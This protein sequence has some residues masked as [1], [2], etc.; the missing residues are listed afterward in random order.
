MTEIQQSS[1]PSFP[2]D[3]QQE[4]EEIITIVTLLNQINNTV[5]FV[6]KT[7]QIQIKSNNPYNQSMIQ[8]STDCKNDITSQQSPENKSLLSDLIIN[9]LSGYS[10]YFNK[11]QITLSEKFSNEIIPQIIDK[12]SSNIKLVEEINQDCLALNGVRAKYKLL[13]GKEAKILKEIEE[14]YNDKKTIENDGKKSYNLTLKEKN[15][16]LLLNKLNEYDQ[17]R[18]QR[19]QIYQESKTLEKKINNELN[20]LLSTS[21]KTIYSNLI[22]LKN[23]IE[24]IIDQ[25][26]IKINEIINITLKP[27]IKEINQIEEAP[28]KPIEEISIDRDWTKNNYMQND[29][30][31]KILLIANDEMNKISFLKK[32]LNSFLKTIENIYDITDDTIS[33]FNK[34]MKNLS[35]PTLKSSFTK[36]NK[37]HEFLIQM[38]SFLRSIFELYLKKFDE[39][40]KC[41]KKELLNPLEDYCKEVNN[42]ENTLGNYLNKLNKEIQNFKTSNSKMLNEKEKLEIEYN[43]MKSEVESNPSSLSKYEKNFLSIKSDI[44]KIQTKLF[45]AFSKV[46]PTLNEFN[47]NVIKKLIPQRDLKKIDRFKE[48]KKGCLSILNLEEQ[49]FTQI[50]NYFIYKAQIQFDEEAFAKYIKGIFLHFGE[51]YKL[52]I[53]EKNIIDIISKKEDV[54]GPGTLFPMI[55]IGEIILNN[56]TDITKIVPG[57]VVNNFRGYLQSL[58]ESGK[59]LSMKNV[60]NKQYFEDIF[61]LEE[62]ETILAKYSSALR[63]GLL[64]QGKLYL[65]TH[66]IVFFS[67]FNKSTLFGKSVISIPKEDIISVEKK[68]N[69][70]FSNMIEVKTKKAVF[71]FC[72]LASRDE[73]YY[74]LRNL[75]FNEALP[76]GLTLD[77]SSPK[78]STEI[79]FTLDESKL[80]SNAKLNIITNQINSESNQE[81]DNSTSVNDLPSDR[82]QSIKDKL[83]NYTQ[84][85]LNSFNASLKRTYAAEF[86]TNVSVGDIS[87]PEV[88]NSL[89]NPNI[90]IPFLG[91]K[92]FF[93]AYAEKKQDYNLDIQKP[94]NNDGIPRYYLTGKTS[95]LFAQD[96]FVINDTNKLFENIEGYSFKIKCTHPILK[97]RFGG[98]SKLEIIDTIQVYFISP[99]CL[100]MEASS[101]MSGFMYMDYFIPIIRFTFTS[102]LII[103]SENKI[104]F[105]TKYTVNFAIE[106][107]KSTWLKGR[108]T[109]EAISDNKDLVQESMVPLVNSVLDDLLQQKKR[110]NPNLDYLFKVP[111]VDNLPVIAPIVQKKEKIET[112]PVNLESD[113]KINEILKKNEY[114]K[115]IS[116]KIDNNSLII[117]GGVVLIIAIFLLFKNELAILSILNIFGFGVILYKINTLL[118][119]IEK[120]EKSNKDKK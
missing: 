30:P 68:E 33:S 20:N 42:D 36:K 92:T 23:G 97:R 114:I 88:F 79:N 56:E 119:K 83:A 108:I 38:M 87:L 100:V 116:E 2:K 67:W 103:D 71:L 110:E 90:D 17:N 57:E 44:D 117:V 107:V 35:V 4:N 43:N 6:N 81:N 55:N 99:L 120:I 66:K 7:F 11:L 60:G 39:R 85:R 37:E 98:P 69:L 26:R 31:K 18:D 3:F 41:I 78:N 53:S 93:I 77:D 47:E 96:Q 13:D 104:S 72:S 109:S 15:D 32:I 91:N 5:D 29:V 61:S 25:Y 80:P 34:D 51:K 9:F 105:D 16:E 24:K 73:C 76:E 95:D 48:I 22:E 59:E 74:R 40:L 86:A 113:I 118:E 112:K 14:I 75:C 111:S 106:F 46:R 27:L 54:E 45:D 50:N 115:G 84:E 70:L 62:G 1:I 63:E 21:I 89:F 49:I 102:D 64:L 8:L 10:S 12:N 28:N 65:T 52:E 58:K 94:V 101:N 82:D 19:I